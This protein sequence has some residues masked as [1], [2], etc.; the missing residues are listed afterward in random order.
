MTA[1][2]RTHIIHASRRKYART[3][4]RAAVSPK[5]AGRAK[6]RDGCPEGDSSTR[7]ETT[8]YAQKY[9]YVVS[10]LVGRRFCPR[11]MGVVHTEH[12]RNYR[13]NERTGP[14]WPAAEQASHLI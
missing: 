1:G 6:E 4:G 12:E 14:T 3:L 7:Q 11:R 2:V 9:T 5:F 13:R 8:Q 10:R